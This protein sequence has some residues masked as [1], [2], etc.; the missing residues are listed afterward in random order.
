[1]EILPNKLRPFKKCPNHNNGAFS[2][3]WSIFIITKGKCGPVL[4]HLAN[5]RNPCEFEGLIATQKSP[6]ATCEFLAN[7]GFQK[8]M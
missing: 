2:N 1:M 8:F 7:F 4:P 6:F 5:F 3:F